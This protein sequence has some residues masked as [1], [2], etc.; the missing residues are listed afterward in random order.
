MRCKNEK[1]FINNQFNYNYVWAGCLCS[2]LF[3]AGK[4]VGLR[5]IGCNL[6]FYWKFFW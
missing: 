3:H 2:R 4:V 1:R 6:I 5:N